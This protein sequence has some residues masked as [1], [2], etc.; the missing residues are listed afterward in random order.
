[1]AVQQQA[2]ARIN[3]LDKRAQ[4]AIDTDGNLWGCTS[5]NPPTTQAGSFPSVAPLMKSVT[6]S[7]LISGACACLS[8]RTYLPAN[9]SR[10]RKKMR[11]HVVDPSSA[12]NVSD[13][14]VAISIRG[15]M[16]TNVLGMAIIKNRSRFGAR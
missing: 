16:G 5:C 2:R 15:K 9:P 8:I 1:M 13:I 10:Y 7:L 3:Y 11:R 6:L 12:K 4:A 14:E